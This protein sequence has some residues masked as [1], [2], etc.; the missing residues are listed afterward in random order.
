MEGGLRRAVAFLPTKLEED[1]NSWAPW[2]DLAL[3]IRLAEEPCFL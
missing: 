2:E 1:H 3:E